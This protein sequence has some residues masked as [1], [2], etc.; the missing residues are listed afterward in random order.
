MK[1][2][3]RP[4]NQRQMMLLPPSVED[5]VPE[6]HL[7]RFIN[8]AVEEL[9]ISPIQH[10]YEQ[11]LRG[12]PP[13]HP[14]MLLKVLLY[15]YCTGVRSSRK[16][17]KRCIEDYAFRYL[18]ANNFPDFRTIADFRR[19]HIDR[20][21]DLFVEV[22]LL[23]K[24]A[25]LASLGHVS[26]DGT[27]IEA[28]AS[29]NK[30][31]NYAYIKA[32]EE[33]LVQE[34]EQMV[35]EAQN[36]DSEE[37]SRYGKD[38]TG[39]EVP[40]ELRRKESRVAK[41]REAKAVIEERAKEKKRR[42]KEDGPPLAKD[43]DQYNFTDPD[44]KVMP[45]SGDKRS[46]LQGYNAQAAVTTDQIIVANNLAAE[47]TDIRQLPAML[48]RIRANNGALPEELAAD[49]GYY[50]E[51][52]VLFLRHLKV[53]A[54]IPTDGQREVVPRSK[55]GQRSFTAKMR[56]FMKTEHARGRFAIRKKTVEPVFGQIK[57][58]MSFTRFSLRGLAKAKGEWDL[59]CLCHNLRKLFR[60]RLD[61]A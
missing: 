54:F 43:S 17:A 46:F 23:C 58:C 4:Y 31:M 36:I 3:Y 61:Q 44:S 27:K 53:Q 16:I 45:R 34:I 5:L 29:K 21:Q 48:A 33:R 13:Y 11:E 8:D 2:T 55:R 20:F 50:S 12:Y 47:A 40:E 49:T 1:K 25:G 56:R 52:N 6:D 38:K 9:D 15:G 35:A 26:L 59:V 32:E 51:A 19:R 30:A 18:A 28:N 37:D 42:H 10:V 22:L 60:F 39:D 7:A 57:A 41:L 14:R 24:A